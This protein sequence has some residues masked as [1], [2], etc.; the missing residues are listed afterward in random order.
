MSG[1]STATPNLT[2]TQLW[3][4]QLKEVFQED[5]MGW[6]YIDMITDRFPDGDTLNIPS[7]GEMEVQDYAEGQPIRYTAMDT[8][9]FQFT[10]TDYLSSGTYIYDKYKQDSFYSDRLVAKFVP[11]MNRA[12]Q[13]RME[14]DA[15]AIGPDNQT[16]SNPNTINSAAHRFVAQGTNEVLTYQDFALAS[17]ALQKANAPMTNLVAIIDPSAAMNLATQTNIMNLM[18]PQ[19]QWARIINQGAVTGMRF[20]ANIWGFDVYVSNFLK[21]NTTSETIDLSS[22]GGASGTAAAGVNN[23]FFSAAASPFI[24]AIRQAPRVEQERNKDYQRDEYVVTCRYGLDLFR[25][26]ALV[27]I[28]TDMDQ[29]YA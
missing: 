17:Y 11:S 15:M 3:D 21:R 1:F 24:G 20:L 26:E 28:V 8:G 25:P 18:T 27:T 13:E 10:I 19:P 22:L 23:L 9:N 2:R 12:L 16:A 6:K 7:I 29:V 4:S 5:L 14:Q